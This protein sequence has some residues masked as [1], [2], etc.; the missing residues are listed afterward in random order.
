MGTDGG[1]TMRAVWL[2]TSDGPEALT[3][4]CLAVPL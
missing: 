2:G 3:Q 4:E 1:R